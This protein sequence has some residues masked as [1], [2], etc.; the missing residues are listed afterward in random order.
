MDKFQKY[1]LEWKKPETKD[2]KMYVVFYIK[3]K[4]AKLFYGVWSQEN[5]F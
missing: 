1:I 3:F 2:Y 4:Q 5:H